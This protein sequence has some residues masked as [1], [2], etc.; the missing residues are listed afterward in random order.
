MPRANTAVPMPIAPPSVTPIDED[1]QLDAG[2]GDADRHTPSGEAGHQP[3][4]WPRAEAGAD[5]QARADGDDPDPGEHHHDP[6]RQLIGFRDDREDEVDHQADLDGV[7]QRAESGRLPQ[8]DPQQQQQ[9]TRDDDDG[10]HRDAGEVADARVEHV[11]RRRPEVGRQQEGDP[12]AEQ[13]QPTDA[14]TDPLDRS[15]DGEES[16]HPGTLAIGIRQCRPRC[17]ERSGR[18]VARS[19]I[20]VGWWGCD[21]REWRYPGGRRRVAWGGGTL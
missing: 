11:P 9:Q 21:E 6:H 1:G 18:H 16:T 4:P 17:D 20:A 15:I 12:D 14:P 10:A 13:R 19:L 5:V 3:V 7:Q 2:A 8:R